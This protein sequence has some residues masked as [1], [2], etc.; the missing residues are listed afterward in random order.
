MFS[1]FVLL[2]R[3]VAK[4]FQGPR[5]SLMQDTPSPAPSPAG[6]TTPVI[7]N[8]TGSTPSV[9]HDE[10]GAGSN[11]TDSGSNAAPG[12]SNAAA[13]G[14]NAAPTGSNA[15]PSSGGSGFHGYPQSGGL[16]YP[17]LASLLLAI[18]EAHLYKDSK[19]AV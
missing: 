5:R 16:L 3:P 19:T 7:A 13:S 12:G 11:A 10:T 9:L 6:E 8:A 4:P 17:E 2:H 18:Q 15:A 14:S 1:F